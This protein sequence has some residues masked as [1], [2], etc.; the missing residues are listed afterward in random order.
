[1]P[2]ACTDT[3]VYPP[4]PTTPTQADFDILSKEGAIAR[5]NVND[6][7]L[8]TTTPT[9][10]KSMAPT[11]PPE[12]ESLRRRVTYQDSGYQTRPPINGASFTAVYGRAPKMD[13]IEHKMGLAAMGRFGKGGPHPFDLVRSAPFPAQDNNSKSTYVESGFQTN[14]P[15]TCKMS[16]AKAKIKALRMANTYT[17]V[18]AECG[19]KIWSEVREE[20]IIHSEQHQA[21]IK[22]NSEGNAEDDQDLTGRFLPNIYREEMLNTDQNQKQPAEM[23]RDEK[24]SEESAAADLMKT[25]TPSQSAS[26]S[27]AQ[28]S[29]PF[30]P[31][32]ALEPADR[33]DPSESENSDEF[34]YM[35]REWYYDEWS[36]FSC[37]LL[38]AYEPEAESFVA[39]D[40]PKAAAEKK[41]AEQTAAIVA[42]RQAA[43]TEEKDKARVKLEAAQAA[44][45][46]A[47]NTHPSDS[48]QR[49]RKAATEDTAHD[50]KHRNKRHRSASRDGRTNASM[51]RRGDDD[52]QARHGSAVTPSP[53]PTEPKCHSR[54]KQQATASSRERTM[55]FSRP[56]RRDD[57]R[58]SSGRS[59]SPTDARKHSKELY[60]DRNHS[61]RRT[62]E[63]GHYSRDAL[64]IEGIA[65]DRDDCGLG[66]ANPSINAGGLTMIKTY[67]EVT[68]TAQ[69]A[70]ETTKGQPH[71]HQSRLPKS[72]VKEHKAIAPN[73]QNRESTTQAIS[74]DKVKHASS[75][76][77][78]AP[79][80]PAPHPAQI[81]KDT[82]VQ[83]AK[84]DKASPPIPKGLRNP[85]VAVPRNAMANKAA[86]ILSRVPT[87]VQESSLTAMKTV[88]PSKSAIAHAVLAP[89]TLTLD[90]KSASCPKEEVELKKIEQQSNTSLKNAGAGMSKELGATKSEQNKPASRPERN[91]EL[92]T[93]DQPKVPL[94]MADTNK[95]A[96]QNTEKRVQ[97]APIAHPPQG[98]RKRSIDAVEPSDSTEDVTS[99]KKVKK[100]DEPPKKA[101]TTERRKFEASV[102]R[103][104]R[105]DQQIYSS[106]RR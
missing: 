11:S 88:E 9:A 42:E 25:A 92:K 19:F 35:D 100:E 46:A 29:G 50:T 30:L 14:A 51:D 78:G 12:E 24:V 36:G 22:L 103:P 41:K 90:S 83:K 18:A 5:V 2:D 1:M 70:P 97:Q 52:R 54:F 47:R 31:I 33:S 105:P 91:A 10:L 87:K 99:Q 43:L 79:T 86:N 98:G 93:P 38:P 39:F 34:G 45:E 95:S 44:Q 27:L 56:D 32:P 69:K 96:K 66:Q 58:T 53:A 21:A 3:T 40:P 48:R 15:A 94:K 85:G 61:P 16:I 104:K 4:S 102:R 67:A 6:P 65:D 49:K 23:D 89:K 71:T 59:R 57:T 26:D 13:D 75:A 17:G 68:K 101:N 60:S 8:I 82:G 76:P 77:Q 63:H 62:G 106:R 73:A 64:R 37:Q 7:T 74:M 55:K 84:D 81:S 72:V 80:G 28:H 20:N